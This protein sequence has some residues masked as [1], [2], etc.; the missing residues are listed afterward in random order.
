MT[1]R[2]RLA[3]ALGCSEYEDKD[4]ADIIS[5]SLMEIARKAKNWRFKEF[6]TFSVNGCYIL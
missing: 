1:N 2:E 4:V 5:D 6:C 3:L